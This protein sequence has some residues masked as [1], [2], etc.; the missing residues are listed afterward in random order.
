MWWGRARH[1]PYSSMGLAWWN[2]WNFTFLLSPS[3]SS[4]VFILS[5]AISSL[6]CHLLLH[7]FFWYSS[8]PQVP[9]SVLFLSP[10]WVMERPL[11]SSMP[12]SVAHWDPCLLYSL[13]ASSPNSPMLDRPFLQKRSFGLFTVIETSWHHIPQNSRQP[14]AIFFS[15]SLHGARRKKS[16]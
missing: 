10:V 11:H 2:G 3:L 9:I 13:W 15:L 1:Q 5:R 16:S 12:I 7:S 4:S 8:K 14:E 6:L